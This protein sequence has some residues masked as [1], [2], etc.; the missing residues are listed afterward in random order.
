MHGKCAT[1]NCIIT[2]KRIATIKTV[3]GYSMNCESGTIGKVN[4]MVPII[5]AISAN[6]TSN[7][8]I[9][10]MPS[11]KHGRGPSVAHIAT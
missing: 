2:K 8:R 7:E 3:K 5:S 1:I 11:F 6:H 9:A 10:P 4:F